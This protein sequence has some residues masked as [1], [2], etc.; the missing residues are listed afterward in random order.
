MIKISKV[1]QK[2]FKSFGEKEWPKVDI[3]RYGHG[4]EWNNH[5]FRFKATENGKVLGTISGDYESGIIYITFIITAQGA[6]GK[7]VGTLLMQEAEEFGKKLGAH[8]IWLITGKDW[9]ENAF[10]KKLGFQIV[11]TLP[12]FHFHK[13]FIIY[14]KAIK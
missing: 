14:T 12:D 11:G 7:G 13:D 1:S 4:V 3:V 8:R 5:E 2:E 6:R 9:P 10:Y